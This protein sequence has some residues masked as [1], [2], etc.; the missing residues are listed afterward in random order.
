MQS[1]QNL[2]VKI[3]NPNAGPARHTTA[4]EV[5]TVKCARTVLNLPVPKVLAWSAT[6]QN[7]VETEYPIME[8]AK[9]SQRHIVWPGLELRTKL[10]IIH[11]I[12]DIGKKLL[13]VS[14]DKWVGLWLMEPS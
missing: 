4:S 7:P 3:S 11:Q 12:F 14:F 9:G 10:D 5:A 1:N 6:N 13:S 2:T 8:E